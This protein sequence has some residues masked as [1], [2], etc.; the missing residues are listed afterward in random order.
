M[1]FAPQLEER[2]GRDV[3][4]VVLRADEPERAPVDAV[5]VQIEQLAECLTVVLAR[6]LP[7]LELGRIIRHT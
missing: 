1:P 7:Q 2:G 3:L 6:S 5:T 4:G